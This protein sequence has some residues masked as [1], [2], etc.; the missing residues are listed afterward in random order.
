MFCNGTPLLGYPLWERL[1]VLNKVVTEKYGYLNLL[2]RE[3]KKTMDDVIEALDHA[4]QMRLV[5][6]ACTTSLPC[7]SSN[8]LVRKASS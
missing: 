7:S 5:F 3:E 8:R 2:G 1:A 6:D 4:I